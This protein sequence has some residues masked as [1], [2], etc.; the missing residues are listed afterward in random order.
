ML[1]KAGA[2]DV[3]GTEERLKNAETI[4]E[5]TSDRRIVDPDGIPKADLVFV[6]LEDGDRTEA[7]VAMGKHVVTV[8]LNP[9]SRTP[10]KRIFQL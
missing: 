10:R 7:L 5:L 3:L 4:P 9:I 6:P 2:K 1:R 8:D